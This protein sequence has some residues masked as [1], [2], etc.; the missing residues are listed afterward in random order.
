MRKGRK[1]HRRGREAERD[2]RKSVQQAAEVFDQYGDEIEAL[3]R[4][5]VQDQ[6]AIDDIF[7]NLF[8][9]LVNKPIPPGISNIKGYLY[10]AVTNDVIDSMRRARNYQ[11]QASKIV[12]HRDYVTVEQSPDATVIEVEEVGR[13]S[14]LIKERLPRS[15]AQAVILTCVDEVGLGEA[16][17]RMGVNPRTV[18]RYKC[19]G[20][21]KIRRYLEEQGYVEQ[22]SRGIGK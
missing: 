17:R 22:Y 6:S 16:G 1:A 13:L 19:I 8:L 15:E 14:E 20:L 9:S 5:Q 12:E 4:F 18:S 3:I 2:V 21:R 7:Q 11:N 10:R